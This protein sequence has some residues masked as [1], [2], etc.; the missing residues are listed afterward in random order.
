MMSFTPAAMR[1]LAMATPAAPAPEMTTRSS[2]MCLPTILQRVLQGGQRDDGGAVLVVVEDGDVEDLAQPLLDLEAGRG[3]DVLEVDAAVDR[4]DAADRLDD[5]VDLV[6]RAGVLRGV[7]ADREGVD[8]GE[9]LEQE[10]LPSITGRTA[11]GPMS[12]RPSTAVPSVTM[13][14]VFFLIVSSWARCGSVAMAVQT[15]ATPGV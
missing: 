1:I 7:D 5:G 3:G 13:A 2:S 6:L 9:F 10:A 4:G 12:P 14:T 11:S 15:R 8:V